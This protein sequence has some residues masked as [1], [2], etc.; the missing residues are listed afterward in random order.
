MANRFSQIH[1]PRQTR[2]QQRF[3]PRQALLRFGQPQLGAVRDQIGTSRTALQLELLTCKPLL[4]IQQ[5]KR[6]RFGHLRKHLKLVRQ[7]MGD[8]RRR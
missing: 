5:A 3:Q 4:Q 2:F 6:Q 8:I 1:F 7:P